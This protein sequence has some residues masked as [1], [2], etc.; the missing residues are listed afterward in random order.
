M[1]IKENG[2]LKIKSANNGTDTYSKMPK[3]FYWRY[4]RLHWA[5]T[6]LL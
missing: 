3:S 2:C 4:C 1:Y 6:W 5:G